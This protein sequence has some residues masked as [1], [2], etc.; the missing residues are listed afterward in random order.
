MSQQVLQVEGMHCGGCVASVERALKAVPGVH[1]VQVEL[2]SG[3][4]TVEAESAVAVSSLADA[5]R[6]TGFD[7]V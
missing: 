3:R 7:V 6:A 2:E 5:V 1:A 4:V